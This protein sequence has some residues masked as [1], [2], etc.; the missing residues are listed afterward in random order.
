MNTSVLYRLTNNAL[1]HGQSLCLHPDG[2]GRLRMAPTGDSVGQLWRL[3]ARTDG[4]FALRTA[5][6]GECFS[7]DVI[8]DGI[9]AT[10]CL[11]ATGEFT[12]Q[13]WTLTPWQ[14]GTYRLT[15]DFTGPGMSLDTCSDTHAPWLN[16][17]DH[18]GQH[19]TLATADPV[20]GTTLIPALDPKGAVEQTEGP[21]DF[22][23]FARPLGVVRAVMI[24]VDFPDAPAG[25]ASASA[26]AD[27]L[28]G[29]GQAQQLYFDQSYG[30]LTLDVTVRSD[31]GWRRLP[32]SSTCYDL[33]KFESQRDYISAAAALFD[34]AEIRFSDYQMVFVVAA[35][36][37][38]FPLS[39]AFTPLAGDGASSPSGKIRLA[40]TLGHDSYAN[41]YINLVHEIGHLFGLP[42]LYVAGQS[43]DDSKVG[44]WSIMCDIF[45]SV[46]FLGWH[47]H[48]NGW[49]PAARAT[50]LK[51]NTMGW[52]ATLSPLSGS[53][54]LSLIVLPADDVDH[55]SKVFVVELA[56][57]VFGS[58]YQ[59]WGEG[60]L[61]YT[62][63][64]TVPS[65]ASPVAVIPNRVGDSDAYGHLYKAPYG[66]GDIA[67]GRGSGSMSLKVEVL[68]KFGSSYSIRIEYRR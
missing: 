46:S 67:H 31:L 5:D 45:H 14:D 23:R 28:L 10:P 65:G 44:C 9:N 50:Y 34:P 18:L 40:V 25:S 17:G 47:R 20:P 57:P 16:T 19:W 55:P 8:N 53:C 11:A 49:L 30:R 26:A 43:V 35:D 32:R 66:V 54:G 1:G 56:Q 52:R 22:T 6:L 27:H 60:V 61:V 21:T 68:Q 39:P 41:R 51:E 24:F 62:V 58:D 48:K 37:P 64:A 33:G 29:S 13:M 4:K 59:Y 2:S 3:V 42:D 36:T 38:S 7:L 12:G 15:N 63:D